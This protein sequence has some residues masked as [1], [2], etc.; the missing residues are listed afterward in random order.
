M[1]RLGE[2]EKQLDI[3]LIQWKMGRLGKS[4]KIVVVPG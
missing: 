1:R 4:K 3:Y 2:E